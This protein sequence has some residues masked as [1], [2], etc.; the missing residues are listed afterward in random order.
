MSTTLNQ[1]S[2]L[3]AI[4]SDSLNIIKD[5]LVET[6]KPVPIKFKSD[7]WMETFVSKYKEGYRI[8][9]IILIK[10]FERDRNFSNESDE[11]KSERLKKFQK[12]IDKKFPVFFDD[13][14]NLIDYLC[15]LFY[16]NQ[17]E[18]SDDDDDEEEVIFK[19]GSIY[20]FSY[21]VKHFRKRI[22]KFIDLLGNI[23]TKV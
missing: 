13:K 22:I 18:N 6:R 21:T 1:Q 4:P 5:F 10:K 19:M 7:D 23:W 12:R 3:S 11:C 14:D 9:R 17:H 15:L 16:V 8:D 20:G 2:I